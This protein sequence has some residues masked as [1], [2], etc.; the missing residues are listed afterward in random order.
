MLSKE[1]RTYAELRVYCDK[2]TS[3]IIHLY[4]NATGQLYS[5]YNDRVADEDLPAGFYYTGNVHSEQKPN[6]IAFTGKDQRV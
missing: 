5:T 6:N 3:D 4:V 2:N 1:K